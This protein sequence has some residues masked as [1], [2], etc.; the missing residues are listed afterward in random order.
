MI[1]LKYIS[2]FWRTF[3]MPLINCKISHMLTWSKNCFLVAGTGANQKPRSTI[4]DTKLYVLVV[5]LSSQDNIKLLKQVE[6]SFKRTINWNKYQ[7]KT[8]GQARNKY[9]DSLIDPNFQI[10]KI[11]EFEKFKSNIFFRLQK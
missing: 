7:S 3:E 11:G 1:P 10:L 8:T 9:L 5:T 6:S 2:N 4:T